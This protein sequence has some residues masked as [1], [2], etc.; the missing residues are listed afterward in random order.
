MTRTNRTY[1][2]GL[3][4]LDYKFWKKLICDKW[5]DFF[6]I[7]SFVLALFYVLFLEYKTHSIIESNE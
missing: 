2:P 6:T 1:Q 4:F 3:H 5:T 7:V